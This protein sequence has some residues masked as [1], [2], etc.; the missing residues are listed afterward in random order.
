LN[1][2]AAPNLAASGAALRAG[3][4]ADATVRRLPGVN[5]YFQRVSG[6]LEEYDA[7]EET[8]DPDALAQISDWITSRFAALRAAGKR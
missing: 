4:N 8:F 2:P 3:K 6:P 1:V 7:V 5:H